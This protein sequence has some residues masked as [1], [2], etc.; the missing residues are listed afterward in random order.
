MYLVTKEIYDKLLRCLDEKDKKKVDDLNN[1]EIGNEQG[2]FPQLPPPPPPIPP[3]QP[4]RPPSSDLMDEFDDTNDNDYP[5]NPPYNQGDNYE[6]PRLERQP[7]GTPPPPTLDGP[8]YDSNRINLQDYSDDE[9][10]YIDDEISS[11]F[12]NAFGPNS[13]LRTPMKKGLRGSKKKSGKKNLCWLNINLMLNNNYHIDQIEQI[14][15]HPYHLLLDM[16]RPSKTYQ[17]LPLL[18]KVLLD[19]L[20]PSKTYQYLPLLN[21]VLLDM[22]CPSETYQHLPLLNKALSLKKNSYFVGYVQKHFR[23]IELSVIMN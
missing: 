11:N 9:D 2:A 16:L 7:P 13:I 17:Y 21:K 14:P 6:W 10:G 20:C 4:P 22:L 18:N 12:D 19:M 1:Q 23:H 3:P 15:T 5:P 8:F